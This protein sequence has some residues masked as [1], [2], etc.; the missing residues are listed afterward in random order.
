MDHSLAGD[1]IF[2]LGSV[3]ATF[4]CPLP[5]PL[6]FFPVALHCHCDHTRRIRCCLGLYKA[7]EKPSMHISGETLLVILLIG[8]IAGWLA[9][10]IVQGTGFG[11][12]ADI[13]IGIIGAF[14]SETILC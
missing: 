11:I 13:V 2:H 6:K 9:E 5:E 1:W 7:V 14:I 8:L 3:G 10:Q 4:F 12:V